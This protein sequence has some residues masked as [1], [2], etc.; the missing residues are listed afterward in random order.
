MKTPLAPAGQDIVRGF[1]KIPVY[2]KTTKGLAVASVTNVLAEFRHS[3][4]FDLQ[5]I[6]RSIIKTAACKKIQ[7]IKEHTI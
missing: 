7:E 2:Y 4:H 5:K 6:N 1:L 3:Y